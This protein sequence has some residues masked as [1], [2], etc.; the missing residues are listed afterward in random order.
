MF[1]A[2]K[3]SANQSIVIMMGKQNDLGSQTN[4]NEYESV[5]D[6]LKT[7]RPEINVLDVDEYEYKMVYSPMQS[8]KTSMLVCKGIQQA[9]AGYN[10]IIVVRDFT[11]DRVQVERRL[12][13]EVTT[14]KTMLKNKNIK[15][16]SVSFNVLQVQNVRESDLIKGS[17]QGNI[18]VMMGNRSQYDKLD[19]LMNSV[20]TIDKRQTI[21]MIDEVDVNVKSE[22]TYLGL[23]FINNTNW[24]VVQ[25]IGVT[26]TAMGFILSDYQMSSS[27]LIML[28]QNKH[29]KGIGN[30]NMSITEVDQ[31]KD[32]M[33][34]VYNTISTTKHN[35]TTNNGLAH[36]Y[37]ILNKT[38]TLK[39]EHINLAW[40]FYETYRKKKIGSKKNVTTHIQ[41]VVNSNGSMVLCDRELYKVKNVKDKFVIRKDTYEVKNG[42]YKVK[43]D[44]SFVLQMIK[45]NLESVMS[46][47]E[48]QDTVIYL[49]ITS[50]I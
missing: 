2:I 34:S 44:I 33:L 28:N 42:Y 29:Y 32:D 5:V 13:N 20:E 26:A 27:Q 18:I 40:M 38:T 7:K 3:R 43:G 48:I 15:N 30:H 23:N 21:L 10:V 39:E 6:Y 19:E 1:S 24:G 31:T 50:G 47:E 22:K 8:G 41:V 9:M 14:I 17:T 37:I 36:P 35:F 45:V 11:M 16:G 49:E 12:E 46:K 25:R 4:S